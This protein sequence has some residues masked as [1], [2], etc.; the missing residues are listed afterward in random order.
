[1]KGLSLDLS[2]SASAQ[3][4]VEEPANPLAYEYYLR[5]ADLMSNHFFPLAIKM[6]EKSAEIYPNYALT[7][8]YLGQSYNS[9]ASFRFGGREQYKKAR[10]RLPC[11]PEGDARCDLWLVHF[12]VVDLSG[13]VRLVVAD[14]Q[15]SASTVASVAIRPDKCYGMPPQPRRCRCD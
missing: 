9:T 6:L 14:F 13:R 1:M 5:G 12:C 11:T 10:A 3:M 15:V 7:W 8:A 2:P 4:K